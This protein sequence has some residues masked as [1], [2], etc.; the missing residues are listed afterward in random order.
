MYLLD[1]EYSLH[2]IIN[3]YDNNMNSKQENMT[4]D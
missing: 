3:H 1:N 2:K 4:E